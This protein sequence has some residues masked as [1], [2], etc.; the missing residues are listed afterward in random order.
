MGTS[1]IIGSPKR[2]WAG[3]VATI[4][5]ALL[6]A[7]AAAGPAQSGDL[8]NPYEYSSYRYAPGPAAYY[9]YRRNCNSCG[10]YQCGCSRCGCCATTHRRSPVIERHWVEREYYERRLPVGGYP[11]RSS[12]YADGY[13]YYSSPPW[14]APRPHLGY[15]GIN[16]G[17]YPISYEYDAPRPPA[18]VPYYGDGYVE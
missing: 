5:G 12:G 11:Y 3:Y 1:A 6:S 15:G 7:F 10:C 9:G 17:P 13:P 14:G 16:Y 8:Y 2:P 18:D 4:S